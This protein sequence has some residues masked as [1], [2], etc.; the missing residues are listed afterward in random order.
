MVAMDI[1]NY[2]LNSYSVT[3]LYIKMT[4]VM[5]KKLSDCYRHCDRSYLKP[6]LPVLWNQFLPCDSFFIVL[7]FFMCLADFLN[8]SLVGHIKCP[9]IDRWIFHIQSLSN[10]CFPLQPPYFLKC[11]RIKKEVILEQSEVNVCIH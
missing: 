11:F 6:W 10:N 9:A 4:F 5:I 1:E 3:E 8:G 7:L 2:L